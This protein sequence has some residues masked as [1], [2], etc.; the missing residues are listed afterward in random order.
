M[1][2]VAF[3]LR[4]PGAVDTASFQRRLLRGAANM[5]AIIVILL[6]AA[7]LAACSPD[8]DVTGSISSCAKQ[9]YS[10]YNPRNMKQCVGACIACDHGITTTCTTS[11]TLKGAR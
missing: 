11:C 5:R 9:L 10:P 3:T 8:N 4:R 1:L 7:A 6:S 2:G